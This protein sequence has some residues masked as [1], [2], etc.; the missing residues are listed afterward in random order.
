MVYIG[1]MPPPPPPPPANI[2]KATT[3][4]ILR[5]KTKREEWEE[6]GGGGCNTVCTDKKENTIF[7]I[8]KEIEKGGVAK[9]YM[10]NGL[11]LHG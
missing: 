6:R 4:H 11:L 2:S 9:S 8:Y 3:C 5:G 1:C 7:L 10:T